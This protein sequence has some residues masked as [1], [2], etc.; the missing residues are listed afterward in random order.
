MSHPHISPK[1]GTKQGHLELVQREVA[2]NDQIT[3]STV[4][5]GMHGHPYQGLLS[6]FKTHSQLA[7]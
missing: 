7:I 4:N 6:N 3:C 2:D 5:P 1:L